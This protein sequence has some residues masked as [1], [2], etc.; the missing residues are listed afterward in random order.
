[1]KRVSVDSVKRCTTVDQTVRGGAVPTSTLHF[2]TN[3]WDDA[4]RL[5]L[6]HHYSRRFPSANEFC[7]TLHKDGGLFGDLGNA[8]AACVFG[9]PPARWKEPVLELTR[10]VRV[11]EMKPPLSKLI[12]LCEKHL[13][14]LGFD[15]LISYAD[16]TA[17]HE[18]YVYR[19]ANWNFARK[20]GRRM[21]GLS[22][23]G[24]YIPGRQCNNNYGT[25]SPIEL[26]KRNP[27]YKIDPVYDVGKNL[28]WKALG[29]RGIAKAQRLGLELHA[30]HSAQ[31]GGNG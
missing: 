2:C 5:V 12:S 7:G 26:A 22:I 1:M 25:Q 18:G 6:T 9:W 19:A 29:T 30:D 28:Y 27:E 31:G 3:Q 23:N 17:G 8:V 14:R 24:T 20:T 15:L 13:K 4:R 10:L 11:P 16:L 21:V